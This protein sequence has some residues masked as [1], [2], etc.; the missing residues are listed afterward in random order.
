MS[1]FLSFLPYILVMAV[2]TYLI[3]L[4]PM[5]FIR[6]RITNR[7]ALS[8]L[9]YIPYAVLSAM[10]FPA[11]IFGTGSVVSAIIGLA[12][13]A[14]AAYFEK[15]LITVALSACGAALVVEVLL[16]LLAGLT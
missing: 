13:G 12:A 6:K 9:Y 5:A 8:F 14:F 3:R 4:I 10:T 7:F 1:D 11:I 15:S 2:V 16:P